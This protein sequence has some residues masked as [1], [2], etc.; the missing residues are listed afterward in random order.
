MRTS[1][2]TVRE[3]NAI[4]HSEETK[5]RTIKDPERHFTRKRKLSYVMLVSLILSH[6]QTTIQSAL[7]HFQPLVDAGITM[8]QS[9]FSQ[10]RAR[11]NDTVFR[12][13]F[14]MTARTGYESR[15]AFNKAGGQLYEGRL[16]CAIDGS[17]VKLPYTAELKEYFGTSG[18]GAKRLLRD[19][20]RF[21]IFRMTSCWMPCWT[22]SASESVRRR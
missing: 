9:A 2:N 5:R 21:M 20:R 4:I 17:Q 19:V 10:A 8:Y 14:E 3:S 11:I 16:V 12:E 22:S 7:N 15:S 6:F 18:Q 13:L 1:K